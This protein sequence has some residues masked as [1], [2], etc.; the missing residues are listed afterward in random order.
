MRPQFQLQLKPEMEMNLASRRM[1]WIFQY[2][3]VGVLGACSG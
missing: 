3:Q 1:M 2:W